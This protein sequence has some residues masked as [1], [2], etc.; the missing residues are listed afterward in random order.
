MKDKYS[1]TW[2]NDNFPMVELEC[3]Y[4]DICGFYDPKK[5]HYKALC[6]TRQSLRGILEPFVGQECMKHQIELI[7][8]H[9]NKGRSTLS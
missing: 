2:I 1:P 4:F 7:N 6:E 9:G 8:N 5:C 3:Q